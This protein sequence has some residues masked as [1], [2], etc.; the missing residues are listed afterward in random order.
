MH[1]WHYY[2]FQI[3]SGWISD[4][5]LQCGWQLAYEERY[6]LTQAPNIFKACFEVM[7][8]SFVLLGTMYVN[9]TKAMCQ[10]LN[11]PLYSLC[12]H[13]HAENRIKQLYCQ[14]DNVFIV[15]LYFLI[16]CVWIMVT[17]LHSEITPSKF[18]RR[19][20]SITTHKKWLCSQQ[21]WFRP[22][23]KLQ[24]MW[25]MLVQT[26]YGRFT[27]VGLKNEKWPVF[28][29]SCVVI[30]KL[31]S[32]VQLLFCG[33]NSLLLEAKSLVWGHLTLW[34]GR[35]VGSDILGVI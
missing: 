28:S 31:E 23:R 35:R 30:L 26:N 24:N 15:F 5:S 8:V 3:C 27:D 19:K 14:N 20:S 17:L 21:K 2:Q 13:H 11:Q 1:Y 9:I 6:L 7:Q 25:N 32:G 22:C 12:T 34:G 33:A 4:I 10:L 18:A 16:M 29:L